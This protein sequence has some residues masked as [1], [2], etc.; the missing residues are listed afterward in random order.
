VAV[1]KK[2]GVGVAGGWKML[3]GCGGPAALTARGAIN[4]SKVKRS[5]ARPRER[6]G[7]INGKNWLAVGQIPQ[8]P[9]SYQMKL[10]SSIPHFDYFLSFTPIDVLWV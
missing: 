5:A 3:G 10:Q 2:A 4:H 1:G 9:L 8:L 7:M 6:I